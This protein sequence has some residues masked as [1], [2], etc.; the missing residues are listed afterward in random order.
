M[1]FRDGPAMTPLETTLAQIDQLA[2]EAPNVL[3]FPSVPPDRLR[4]LLFGLAIGDALGNSTESRRPSRPLKKSLAWNGFLSSCFWT[5]R[6][7][8]LRQRDGGFQPLR[9]VMR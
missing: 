1:T 4:A 3:A 6:L 7:V 2:S 5:V 9:F 8:R